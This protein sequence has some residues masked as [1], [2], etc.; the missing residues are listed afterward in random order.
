M[1]SYLIQSEMRID[2]NY[3]TYCPHRHKLAQEPYRSLWGLSAFLLLGGG[4]IF[5]EGEDGWLF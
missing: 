4:F 2:V 5:Q 1:P 3:L